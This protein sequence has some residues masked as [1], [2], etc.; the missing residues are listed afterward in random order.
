MWYTC[1]SYKILTIFDSLPQY[2]WQIVVKTGSSSEVE[3]RK[4]TSTENRNRFTYLPVVPSL[5][6]LF[7]E[8][9]QLQHI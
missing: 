2:L 9:L 5:A 1:N 3:N 8:G 7:A 4:Q 6:D